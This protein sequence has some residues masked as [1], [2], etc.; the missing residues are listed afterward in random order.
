MLIV[1]DSVSL[2][3]KWGIL[4]NTKDQPSLEKAMESMKSWLADFQPTLGRGADLEVI[5]NLVAGLKR[6]DLARKALQMIC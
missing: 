2:L 6:L 1:Y 5:W 4:L 3:H